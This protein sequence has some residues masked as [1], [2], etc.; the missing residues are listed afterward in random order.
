MSGKFLVVPLSL[1]LSFC[2]LINVVDNVTQNE[3]FLQ[4]LSRLPI[5]RRSDRGFSGVPILTE[6]PTSSDIVE[7]LLSAVNRTCPHLGVRTLTRTL[8]AA[9]IPDE[10]ERTLPRLLPRDLSSRHHSLSEKKYSLSLFL[11][12]ISRFLFRGFVLRKKDGERER[13]SDVGRHAEE[14]RAFL[15]ILLHKHPRWPAMGCCMYPLSS[16]LMSEGGVLVSQK[17]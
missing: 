14:R 2:L 17:C 10:S 12:R 4:H 9:R 6:N 8:K 3:R 7:R 5:E 11:S 16:T 1:S 15:R 13:V